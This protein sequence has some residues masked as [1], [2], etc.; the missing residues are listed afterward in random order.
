MFHKNIFFCRTYSLIKSVFLQDN[1]GKL[2]R[3]ANFDNSENFP[4]LTRAGREI[5][6]GAH[7]MCEEK[8]IGKVIIESKS[9]VLNNKKELI[10]A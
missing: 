9:C 7:A 10:S 6:S 1:G 3:P 2:E 8:R 5:V 4:V